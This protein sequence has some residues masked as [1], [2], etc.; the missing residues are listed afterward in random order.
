MRERVSARVSERVSECE[1]INN[2]LH[3]DLLHQVPHVGV[4]EGDAVLRGPVH[5]QLPQHG[6]LLPDL[7]G[8]AAGVNACRSPARSS[9]FKKNKDERL[10]SSV[11][12]QSSYTSVVICSPQLK[13]ETG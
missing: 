6:A 9:Q 4:V 2:H 7:L 8:Q 11:F 1:C 12:L 5:N 13:L 3:G 10:R